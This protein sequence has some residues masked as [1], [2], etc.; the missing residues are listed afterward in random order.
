[1][2]TDGIPFL[3]ELKTDLL[4]LLN[5]IYEIIEKVHERE[6]IYRRKTGGSGGNFVYI[7][8]FLLNLQD[9]NSI[10]HG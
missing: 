7:V 9:L 2:K 8:I 6:E 10:Y 3:P 1:M 5:T 4:F